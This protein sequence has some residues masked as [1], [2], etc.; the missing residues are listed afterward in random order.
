MS[1][2]IQ[3]MANQYEYIIFDTPPLAG[4]ADAAVLGK[5]ADGVLMVVRPGVA[6]SDSAIAAKSLLARS[7]S[8]A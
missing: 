1:N 4:T 2:L 6:N 5:M 3:T 7:E 8:S